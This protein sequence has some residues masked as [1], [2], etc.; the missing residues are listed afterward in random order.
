MK[1]HAKLEEPH[2]GLLCYHMAYSEI[3]LSVFIHTLGTD[4]PLSQ[5]N[6]QPH[7]PAIFVFQT[8]IELQFRKAGRLSSVR[9]CMLSQ[10]PFTR[11]GSYLQR[12]QTKADIQQG[13]STIPF[14]QWWDLLLESQPLD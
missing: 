13:C 6:K 10:D 8:I 3:V 9:N 2:T 4:L 7:E 14:R 11:G 5:F 1:C 12:L